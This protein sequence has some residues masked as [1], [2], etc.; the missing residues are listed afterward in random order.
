[1]NSRSNSHINMP[2]FVQALTLLLTLTGI[3]GNENYVKT[4]I[5]KHDILKP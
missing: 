3:M 2:A 5:K 4:N 1:M